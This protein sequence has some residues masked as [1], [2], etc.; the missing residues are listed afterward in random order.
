MMLPGYRLLTR[1]TLLACRGE[2]PKYLSVLDIGVYLGNFYHPE[3][4]VTGHMEGI[5]MGDNYVGHYERTWN[6]YKL[7]LETY[8]WRCGYCDS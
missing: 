2:A 7:P 4:L 5:P 1:P 3:V 6:L 8:Q